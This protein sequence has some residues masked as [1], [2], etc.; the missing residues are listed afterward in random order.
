MLRREHVVTIPE[1]FET[2]TR[3]GTKLRFTLRESF[4]SWLSKARDQALYGSKKGD[5]YGV[6][7]VSIPE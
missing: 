5:R 7:P 6:S 1:V 4:L 2:E 3:K